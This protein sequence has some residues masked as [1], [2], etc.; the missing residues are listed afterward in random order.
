MEKDRITCLT[1]KPQPAT[2]RPELRNGDDPW[3]G[4]EINPKHMYTT[5]EL[6]R[7]WNFHKDTVFDLF[8]DYPRRTQDQTPGDAVETQLHNPEDSAVCGREV[9]AGTH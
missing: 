8:V 9:V 6:G 4:V 3:D 1:R 5:V 2:E 7:K